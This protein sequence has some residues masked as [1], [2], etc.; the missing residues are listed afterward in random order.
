MK[1][2]LCTLFEGSYHL[3]LGVFLNSAHSSGWRGTMYAGYR[4]PLPPW[5][6][7]AKPSA[8]GHRYEIDA[9]CRIEFIKLTTN[10]HLTNYKPDFMLDLWA[11]ACPD[12]ET[13]FYFDPDIVIRCNWAF[14]EEWVGYGVTLVEDLNSPVAF[15]HPRRAGW[16][17]YYK[18]FGLELNDVTEFYVNGGFVGTSRKDLGFLESWK[19]IQECMGKDLGGLDN[20]NIG[21]HRRIASKQQSPTYMFNK[22]DQDALN[23]AVMASG[24]PVSIMG[25]ESM[26]FKLGGYVMSHA[27]GSGK[28]WNKNHFKQLLQ[29][30]RPSNT[31]KTFWQ[32]A[33]SPIPVFSG[34][35]ARVN[36]WI[37]SACSV[38]GRFYSRG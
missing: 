15:N 9:E 24:R 10:V 17:T 22:T 5:A 36:R 19:R 2:A 13:L 6:A 4:G 38:A 3:G 28:P 21:G 14:F 34:K 33:C 25:A 31:D 1:H 16:K 12:A 29:G 18:G 35:Q 30:F 20:A 7:S 32:H 8:L 37:V 26:D 27:V 11:K 23:V